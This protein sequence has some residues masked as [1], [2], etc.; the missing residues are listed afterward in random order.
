[1]MRGRKHYE[2]GM[3]KG[4]SDPFILLALVAGFV[5]GWMAHPDP[6]PAPAV[7]CPSCPTCPEPAPLASPTP[8]R[9]CFDADPRPRLLSYARGQR[10]QG[11]NAG[12]NEGLRIGAED[13]LECAEFSGRSV[14]Q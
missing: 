13:V 3:P 11:F 9:F 12:L 6:K 8:A 2:D 14:G 7:V 5:G 1:M 4:Y 10:T